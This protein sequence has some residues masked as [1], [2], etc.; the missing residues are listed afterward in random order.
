MISFTIPTK[1]NGAQLVAELNAGGVAVHDKC[2]IYDDLLWLNIAA[3]DKTKAEAIVASHLGQDTEP[4]I[5]D[6][7]LQVGLNFDELKAALAI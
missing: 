4:T 5:Q 3:K 6:K 7:L 2:R 1:L